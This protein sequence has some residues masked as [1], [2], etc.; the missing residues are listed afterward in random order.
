MYTDEA[1][2]RLKTGGAVFA[3]TS[4]VIPTQAG[5]QTSAFR[6]HFKTTATSNF[7]IPAGT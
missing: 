1:N 3:E 5:I 4:A 6:E 2:G 7:W